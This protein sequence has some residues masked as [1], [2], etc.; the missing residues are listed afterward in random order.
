VQFGNVVTKLFGLSD[1]IK[2]RL[3]VSTILN[4]FTGTNMSLS[5][6]DICEGYHIGAS[7]NHDPLLTLPI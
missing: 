6:V 4:L 1:S 5:L 7:D 3:A 2:G